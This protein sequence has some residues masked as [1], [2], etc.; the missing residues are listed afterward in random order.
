MTT[1]NL[2]T[3]VIHASASGPY[4]TFPIVS[5]TS[6]FRDEA[7]QARIG[8]ERRLVTQ[9]G[10]HGRRETLSHPPQRRF[11]LISC[12]RHTW[13]G[14]TSC[15]QPQAIA[16]LPAQNFAASCPETSTTVKPPR[17]SGALE[18]RPSLNCS[19]PLMLLALK[20][21]L[22]SS[23]TPAAKTSTPASF[24]S[25]TAALANGPRD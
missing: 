1:C 19:S 21:L 18:Y 23:S 2:P 4:P 12:S 10:H 14:R 11:G 13:S 5:Q 6:A 3:V 22:R 16:S 8:S 25:A 9:S 17:Y 20:A 7:D 24:I 15:G